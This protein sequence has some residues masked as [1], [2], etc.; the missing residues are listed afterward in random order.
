IFLGNYDR[1]GS[2]QP[3]ILLHGFPFNRSMWREQIDFLSARGY[4][5]VAPDLRG[6]GD[7]SDK[8]QFVADSEG[9]ETERQAEACRTISTMEDMARDVAALMDELKIDNA[10][11]CGLSMGCYVAFE[12]IHL[13]P[14]RVRAV[15]L[16]G[17]RAQ[18]PD[19]TEKINREAQALRVLAEGME[20]A[21]ASISTKLLARRTV[22][23]KSDV[24][25]R[26]GEMVLSTDPLGA[27]AAQRG[28][29]A[30]RDYSDDLAKIDVPTLIVAGREDGVRTPEDAEFIDER[31]PNS[32]LIVID[33]A[34]HLMNMEQPQ[35]FNRAM[36][37]FLHS[38]SEARP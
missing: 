13:F 10:I 9:G 23:E 26:V 6:L 3:I 16:C 30:R 37:K 31:I 5:C 29:A 36:L 33:D 28:M 25:R 8:L 18:G 7:M 32:Q 17:P 14:K 4:R 38:V 20:F 22:D 21:V 19:E 34:G 27:A 12:F 1:A 2:G 15:I 24:V 35:R 11:I